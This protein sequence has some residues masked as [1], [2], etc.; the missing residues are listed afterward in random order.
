M[1]HRA[2]RRRQAHSGRN[3]GILPRTRAGRRMSL[4]ERIRLHRLAAPADAGRPAR[5][6]SARATTPRPCCLTPGTPCLVTTDM[7]LEGSCFLLAEAGPRRVGRKAMAVNL[8]DIAAMAGRPSPRSSASA[9]PAR[10]AGPWPRSCIAAC[11]NRRRLRHAHRRRRHQQL[12]RP[13]GHLRHAA[14]R[15]DGP[16]VRCDAAE[17]GRATGSGHRPARRQHPRQAPRLHAAG[18]RGACSARARPRCTR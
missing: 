16:R 13:A 17:R 4:H 11:A 5:P 14:R 7:L 9:C 2:T 3:G 18:P 10:A 6:A 12:G 8:S 15:G 1:V